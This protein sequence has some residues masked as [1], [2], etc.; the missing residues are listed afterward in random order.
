LLK[1]VLCFI[2]LEP[3]DY[4]RYHSIGVYKD[5]DLEI[6]REPALRR[7]NPCFRLGK[8]ELSRSTLSS[9]VER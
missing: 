9:Q 6:Q 8:R 7:G 2:G 1:V 5:I 4:I 3:I